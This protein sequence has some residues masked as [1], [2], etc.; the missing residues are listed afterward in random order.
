VGHGDVE[1]AVRAAG[2]KC[3]VQE[4]I[5]WDGTKCIDCITLFGRGEDFP[6]QPL[7]LIENRQFMTEASL[8]RQ[9]ILPYGIHRA[10]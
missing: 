5:A 3:L 6:E 2:G 7:T 10:R 4:L 8:I 1:A 9:H